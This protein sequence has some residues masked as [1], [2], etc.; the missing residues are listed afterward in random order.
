MRLVALASKA[1]CTYSRYADDLTFSTNKRVPPA[2]IAVQAGADGA[3][4]HIW[5]ASEALQRVIERTGFQINA[6][7]TNLMYR[8]S[9]QDV[10]GLV[11]NDKVNVRW[12]YRHN[13]RAMVHSLVTTGKF[14]I[15]D[16][17]HNKEPAVAEK[18]SGSLVELHGMLGF[19]D[20]IE[21]YNQISD[22]KPAQ[23]S[24]SSRDKVYRDFLLYS[25]FYA[26]EIPVI[27]CEGK[28]DNV[29][30]T[31]AIRSLA[32]EFPDL[33]ELMPNGQIKLKVR[34]FKYTQS[35]TARLLGLGDGGASMLAKLIET[36]RNA[37]KRFR[38]PGFT[39]PV[40]ILHDNDSGSKSIRNAVKNVSKTTWTGKEPFIHVLKNLYT[41]A[42][43][44]AG[45]STASMIEDF[46][47]AAI[48][49]TAIGGKT[50]H[51]GND[52]DTA[53]HYGKA[54]FAQKVIRPKAS[55]I[56]FTGFAPLL[57]NLAA[58]IHHHKA[59]SVEGS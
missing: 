42:T 49:E 21:V 55:T 44:L 12:E 26:P 48:K 57:T 33:A 2:E 4:A 18:R 30:L 3:E 8:S 10:T 22:P 28:T 11:V 56:D 52:L 7:K 36:Y 15:L 53:K 5:L 58:V 38:A 54:I 24:S 20:N 17:T 39:N 19:I 9:R 23:E 40:I 29:Y 13:V 46:F 32:T 14:D 47:D 35:S 1:G 50:F 41:V 25:T 16:V 27:I 45:E 31:H 43:P 6:A 34:L 37:L 51:I 59:L